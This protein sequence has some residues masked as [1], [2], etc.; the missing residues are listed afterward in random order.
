MSASFPTL[1]T[2]EPHRKISI[3]SSPKGGSEKSAS[4]HPGEIWLDTDGNSID[5]HSAGILCDPITGVYFWYGEAKPNSNSPK[6]GYDIMD[7]TDVVGISCYS[8]KDLYRWKNEGLV[9]RSRPDDPSHDLHPSMV[10]ERP[11]VVYNRRTGQYILWMHIDDAAYSL[12]RA[13]VAVSRSPTGPFEYIRSV[14]PLGG[15]SRDLTLF[16]DDNGDAYLL[17]SSENNATIHIVRLSDDYLG[18]AG[19]ASRIFIDQKREAPVIF[20]HE[21]LYY[22][23]TSGLTGWA[24][25]Q[26]L[27]AV[28]A[29]VMGPWK[30]LGD[31]CLGE[32]ATT[33]FRGQ[34]TYAFQAPGG[35][36]IFL[37]DRWNPQCLRD[38]RYIWLP[39]AIDGE[40]VAITWKDSWRYESVSDPMLN[41]SLEKNQNTT[42]V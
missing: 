15:E 25:N 5:A 12:A 22:L 1:T 29:S 17:F 27:Y 38:S 32:N 18:F 23:I 6:S 30:I 28:A 9:L 21:G 11:K 35:Q 37:A 8:S 13:G 39:M 31:P 4:F 36:W 40:K 7:R 33:T 14:R 20:K 19:E 3:F 24:P 16:A 2:P 26:A 42:H 34:G 10:L 41:P